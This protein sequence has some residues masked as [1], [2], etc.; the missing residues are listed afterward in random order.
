[1]TS[2]S[3]SFIV[4]T[5]NRASYLSA[6]LD[7]ILC[8]SRPGDE[9]LVVNDGSTDDTAA[10]LRRYADR[11]AVVSKANGGK[12]A[13]LNTG[14]SHTSNPLVWIVDDDDILHPEARAR[15]MAQLD[16]DPGADLAYGRHLRFEEEDGARRYLETG[17]WLDC[18]PKGFLAATMEDMFVHQPGMLVRRALYEQL[19]GFSEDL[20]RSL[21]YEMLVRLAMAGRA[22]GTSEIVFFQ[23]VHSGARGSAG[24][25]IAAADRDGSWLTHDQRIFDR[26]HKDLPLTA[27]HPERKL[28]DAQDRRLALL[29]RGVIM[30]RKKLWKAAMADFHAGL[31]QCSA[32]L[33]RAE[34]RIVRRAFSSK[35]G[36]DELLADHRLVSDMTNL[37][38]RSQAGRGLAAAMA[39][40]LVWRIR[41][42]LLKGDLTSGM[43]LGE[44]AARLTLASAM[45]QSGSALP[46][47]AFVN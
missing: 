41:A 46:Q 23:R 6:C 20:D 45:P 40:G 37:A 16:A 42:A 34:K 28:E 9:I 15:L 30:T 13:A 11:V 18:H 47:E 8:Q 43:V 17:H 27:Y 21:D 3:I 10:V 44:K 39:R 38:R 32:A 12:S 26:F 4:P 33:S 5:Y 31:D 24:E 14:L 1:M 25:R 22:S 29:Q 36:C 7:S 19:H 35:Y 2:D